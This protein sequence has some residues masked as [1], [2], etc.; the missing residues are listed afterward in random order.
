MILRLFW[1]FFKLGFLSIGGGYPMLTLIFQMGQTEVGLTAG[2][3]ADMSALELLASGPVAINSATYVGFIKGG[4]LGAAIAT[5]AVCLPCFILTTIL[6]FFLQ[7]FR[8]N[9]Y[10]Q[11]FIEGIKI[12]CAGILFTTV[13]SLGK[14]ILLTT[15]DLQTILSNPLEAVR[16]LYFLIFIVILVCLVRFRKNAIAMILVS[17]VLGILLLN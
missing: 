1:L 14:T 9:R 15:A 13:V 3:F 16:W 8:E 10:I 4:I 12:A 6:M 17:A 7:K 11:K 5:L 2:E